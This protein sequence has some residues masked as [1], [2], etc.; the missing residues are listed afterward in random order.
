M[1][2]SGPRPNRGWSVSID[3]AYTVLAVD[4]LVLT[5]LLVPANEGIDNTIIR[6]VG[7]LSVQSDQAVAIED[8][9]GAMGLILVT[10]SAAAIG[11]TAMPDPVVDADDDGWFVYQAFAQQS[12][13]AQTGHNSVEYHFDSK[14]KRI[15]PGTGV[16]VAV[17]V[18]N[19]HASFGLEFALSFRI[20]TQVRGTR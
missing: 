15:V 11:A 14:A 13:G 1:A 2:R 20:L 12:G 19:C 3:C 5:G 18:K 9:M 17:L 4:T 16:N 10:D 6:T 8:Q 7:I